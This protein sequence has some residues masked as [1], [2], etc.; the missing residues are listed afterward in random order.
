M[1]LTSIPSSATGYIGRMNTT[2]LPEPTFGEWLQDELDK[3][4]WSRPRLAR[5]IDLSPGAVT[6]W[7][8]GDRRPSEHACKQIAAAF[9]IDVSEVMDRA[10]H[11]IAPVGEALAQV[12]TD[13]STDEPLTDSQPLSEDTFTQFLS[14]IETEVGKIAAGLR[15]AGLMPVDIDVTDDTIQVPVIGR[16]PADSLRW[17]AMEEESDVD[18]TRAEVGNARS[19]FGLI[20]TG[21]CLRSIG[22]WSGDVVV[23]DRALGREPRDRQL[24]VVRVGNDV[25]LKRWCKTDDGIELR[26][27]DEQTVYR[28][29]AG[30]D[31]EIIG[32][33]L[34]FKPVAER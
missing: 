13:Q 17:T 16:V 6:S 5:Y 14:R 3:R 31:I 22:I 27:G 4:G 34:T 21:D 33:Y 30:D 9:G 15:R 12:P 1:L 18:L 26:D 32:F 2:E 10:G 19:P 11:E 23:C 29:Q 8:R 24:V 28:L 7:I 25:T 20:A